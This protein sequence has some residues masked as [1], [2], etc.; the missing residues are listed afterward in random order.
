MLGFLRKAVKKK[1]TK[2][3]T[4]AEIVRMFPRSVI[5]FRKFGIEF[6]GRD[7]SPLESLE[8]VSYGNKLTEE[9]LEKMIEEINEEMNK[10]PVED[11][12]ENFIKLTDKAADEFTEQLKKKKDK[13]GIRLRLVSSGCALY[14]YDMEYANKRYGDEIEFDTKGIKFFVQKK[15][16]PL[17][18][19]VT[20]DYL[21]GKRGFKFNN[22]HVKEDVEERFKVLN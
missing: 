4:V 6:I 14:V 10:K 19:G 20:I 7:I 2:D 21:Y 22:P 12:S 13:K 11:I 5:S 16:I 17:I 1:I 8:K 18:D 9:A 3:M 15:T